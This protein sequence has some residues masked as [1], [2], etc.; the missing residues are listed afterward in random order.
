MVCFHLVSPPKTPLY[1]LLSGSDSRDMKQIRFPSASPRPARPVLGPPN[2]ESQPSS[3]PGLHASSGQRSG[4]KGGR[5]GGKT[6]GVTRTASSVPGPGETATSSPKAPRHQSSLNVALADGVTQG[7]S[8][9]PAR[10]PHDELHSGKCSSPPRPGVWWGRGGEP[11]WR[12][13]RGFRKR[14]ARCPGSDCGPGTTM[15]LSCGL[16][17]SLSCR[18]PSLTLYIC[19]SQTM[20]GWLTSLS[21]CRLSLPL[22]SI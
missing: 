10:R 8:R 19:P 14:D 17:L 4:G 15:D 2:L 5:R 11:G 3:Y 9:R 21:R 12:S 20:R 6:P 18:P 16:A 22:T 1:T 7:A 13:G